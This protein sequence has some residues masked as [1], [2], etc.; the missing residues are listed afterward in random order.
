MPTVALAKTVGREGA[1]RGG[2]GGGGDDWQREE[3]G[4]GEAQGVEP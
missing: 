2:M 1:S 4:S 3:L